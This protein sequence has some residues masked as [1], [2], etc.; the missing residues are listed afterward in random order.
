MKKSYQHCFPNYQVFSSLRANDIILPEVVFA[1]ASKHTHKY[2]DKIF[3]LLKT[4]ILSSYYLLSICRVPENV[5]TYLFFLRRKWQP[6][7]LFL[8]G[9]SHGQRILVDY[10]P[11][12]CKGV[13]L[14]LATKKQQ[15]FNCTHIDLDE[16]HLH[17]LFKT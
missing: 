14:D 17:K 10:S 13:G 15:I 9:E 3:S 6:T 16:R 2:T 5:L 7:P 11:W 12:G 4:P 1:Y 8:P